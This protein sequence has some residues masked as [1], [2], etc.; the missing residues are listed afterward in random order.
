MASLFYLPATPKGKIGVHGHKDVSCLTFVLQD[1]VGG[2]EVDKD[3]EWI[4]LT[5]I[6]CALIVNIGDALQVN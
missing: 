6:D 1:Q 5:P 4:P 2:L 3:G